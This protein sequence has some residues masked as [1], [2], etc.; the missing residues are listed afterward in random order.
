MIPLPHTDSI[1]SVADWIELYTIYYSK[2]ISKSTII[3]MVD[4]EKETFIDSIFNELLNR[5]ILYGDVSPF[6]VEGRE[7]VPKI[8][9]DKQPGFTMCL[10][11]S[12]WGVQQK[13]GEDVGLNCLKD[14]PRKQLNSI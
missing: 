14:Y 2:T 8:N 3:S 12:I 1:E 6:T 4:V 7:I 9:W 10:I 5:S 13:R 11:F